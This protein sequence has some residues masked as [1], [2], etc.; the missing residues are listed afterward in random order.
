M[1]LEYG[2]EFFIDD[3]P[4]FSEGVLDSQHAAYLRSG[5][6]CLRVIARFCKKKC[7]TLVSPSLCCT[8][9]V[10][11]FLLEGYSVAY[12][13]V[14]EKL[15]IEEDA[16]DKAL[17][18]A[19]KPLL[20]FINH[21]GIQGLNERK[22]RELA[23]RYGAILVKDATHDYLEE[24]AFERSKADYTVA[25]IRKWLPTPAGALL[26]SKD[27]CL[28]SLKNCQIDFKFERS[29]ELAMRK[30]WRYLNTGDAALKVA[31]LNE[32]QI[33]N[34][35]LD[36]YK[37]I[38]GIA[39]KAGELS[40]NLILSSDHEF[41][42]KRRHSNAAFLAESLNKLGVRYYFSGGSPLYLAI[43]IQKRDEIQHF[44]RKKD[45]YLPVLWPLPPGADRVG[46]FAKEFSDAMLAI[47]CDQRYDTDD[48]RVIIDVL[49]KSLESIR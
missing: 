6:D 49:K 21:F 8:S 48:M 17:Q 10:D 1:I 16:L 11:P 45:V 43:L 33:C 41:M 19:K 23:D 27:A 32:L 29:R 39:Y 15:E 40:R 20:L 12:Y 3:S 30:K 34:A 38:K 5:R 36:D 13:P 18:N 26:T 2:S 28:A 24:G 22:Y 4:Q 37:R 14:T 47:P 31:Y 42:R 35:L 46:G 9:M 44:A 25:S 7:S